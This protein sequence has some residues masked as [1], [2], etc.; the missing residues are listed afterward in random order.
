MGADALAVAK[1][2]VLDH[3]PGGRS[4]GARLFLPKENR[5]VGG[6]G[7]E[8]TEFAEIHDQPERLR[9]E[10][11]LAEGFTVTGAEPFIGR[12]KGRDA[13][14]AEQLVG[15]GV[16]VNVKVGAL[17]VDVRKAFP[18]NGLLRQP[19]FEGLRPDKSGKA[20][21]KVVRESPKGGSIMSLAEYRKKRDFTRTREPRPKARRSS[22]RSAASSSA[23]SH[24]PIVRMQWCTRPGP[25]RACAIANPWPHWPRSAESGTRTLRSRISQ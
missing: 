9:V 25:R 5:G 16:E 6:G 3:C 1:R 20:A 14:R 4:H 23:S 21:L 13:A 17:G 12:D 22:V 11:V 15:A 24:W 18:Q 10:Q 8:D 2:Q 19:R 7:I